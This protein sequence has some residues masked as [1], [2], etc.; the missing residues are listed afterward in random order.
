M[1]LPSTATLRS[2]S[3]ALIVLSTSATAV[4][5]GLPGENPTQ[6]KYI[7]RSGVQGSMCAPQGTLKELVNGKYKCY[8][9][10]GSD[11]CG[12][13]YDAAKGKL[14]P[15]FAELFTDLMKKDA[16]LKTTGDKNRDGHLYAAGCSDLGGA[17]FVHQLSVGALSY[18]KSSPDVVVSYGTAANFDVWGAAEREAYVSA[19][20]RYGE[21][22]KDKILPILRIALATKGSM[23][24]FKK[25]ALKLMAR[26]NSDDGVTYC[27]DVL[28]QG[29]DKDTTGVCGFYLGERKKTDAASTLLR[30]L[31]D[32]KDT[33]TRALG[34]MGAA[35]ASS[36][37]K[38]D[39]EK[40]AGSGGAAKVTVALLNLGDKSYDYAGDLT[41]MIEGRRP[42]SLRDRTR[43]ADEL[44]AKKKGAAERWKQRELESEESVARDA[45]LEATY[46]TSAAAAAKIN[47]AL[48]KT[49]ART[50]WPKAAAFAL[51]ALGQRGDKSAIPALVK[52]LDSPKDE[53]RD[54][55][56]GALGA[57][58]DT[59]EA[60]LNYV[61][62]QGV[63]ADASAVPALATFIE[64]EP[65]E[66][67]RA[68][69]LRALGA[70]RSFLP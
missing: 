2:A 62:R 49:A 65:K 12:A 31:N 26:F 53:V 67:R 5:G 19:L 43:K 3:L 10:K 39:Y 29:N 64:N 36:A 40:E 23:L 44:K 52:L 27:L 22:Q 15:K 63:V 11:A 47:E 56:L 33:F 18:A 21:P 59:P 60:F 50:D 42:L 28:K 34:V 32:E 70:V 1:S 61:G 13:S 25:N 46:A 24:S 35:E 45:A 4:A 8:G 6:S 9:P 20:G 55:A 38:A 14:E 51:S 37:L 66:E 17:D 69:A 57:S 7:A 30:R 58:Y 41:A 16:A 54:V 48:R 68:K